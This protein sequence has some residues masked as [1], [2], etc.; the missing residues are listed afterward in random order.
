M[1]RLAGAPHGSTTYYF[2]SKAALISAAGQRLTDLDHQVLDG[3]ALDVARALAPRSG[4]PDLTMIVDT[5]AHWVEGNRDLHIARFELSLA[6]ARDPDLAEV[7]A[8]WNETFLSIIEP[9]VIAA[10][11]SS[12]RLD[13]RYVCAG[14]MGIVF[15]QVVRPQPDFAHAVLPGA[16]HRLL[17]SL[18]PSA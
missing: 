18:A 13:A 9:V 2:R 4:T 10:G 7:E 3:L 6:A 5:L 17:S 16:L 8:G 14:F 12:V 1:E 11:S 15:D